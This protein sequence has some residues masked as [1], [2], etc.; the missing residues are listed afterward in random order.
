[1]LN[2]GDGAENLKM[3]THRVLLAMAMLQLSNKAVDAGGGGGGAHQDPLTCDSFHCPTGYI[4][5]N[6]DDQCLVSTKWGQWSYCTKYQ[7]CDKRERV[8][9][10]LN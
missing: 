7:C 1:M 5:A 3:F 6:Q 4:P 9:F 2:A 8:L 10:M